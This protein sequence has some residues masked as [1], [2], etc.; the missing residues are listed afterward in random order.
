[1]AYEEIRIMPKPRMDQ[2]IMQD[3][4]LLIDEGAK[5]EDIELI[6]EQ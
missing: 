1:M 4:K 5:G 3:D 6:M 2:E